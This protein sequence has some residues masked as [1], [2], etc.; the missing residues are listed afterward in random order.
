MRI[1]IALLF[2]DEI[3]DLI[4]DYLEEVE[5]ISDSGNF[6]SNENLHLTLLYLGETSPAMLERIR[7]KLNEIV[8]KKFFYETETLGS[9]K[10]SQNRRIVYLGV[11]KSFNLE[12]LYNLVVLKLK[13]LG[14]NFP[15][16]KYTPHI[17]LGRQVSLIAEDE[18]RQVKTESLRIQATRISIMESTR[19]DGELTYRE[20]YQIPLG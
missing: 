6:S 14:L 5:S 3:K 10:K 19:I 16:E 18:I 7:Y 15:T 20:L 17:T 13:E 2:E 4:Y 9:F 8:M 1:F 11:K 12:S